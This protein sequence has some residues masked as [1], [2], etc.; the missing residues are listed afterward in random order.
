ML[1]ESDKDR[2]REP[3]KGREG[4]RVILGSGRKQDLV[5]RVWSG[6]VILSVL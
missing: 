1:Q 2:D 4:E 6:D 5:V 3:E